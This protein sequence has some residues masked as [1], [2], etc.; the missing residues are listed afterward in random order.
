MPWLFLEEGVDFIRNFDL[1]ISVQDE[2]KKIHYLSK[3]NNYNMD[4]GIVEHGNHY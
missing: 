1:P 4:G 3:K 2:D